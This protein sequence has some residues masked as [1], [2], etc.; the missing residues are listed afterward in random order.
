MNE[1]CLV[2]WTSIAISPRGDIA[3]CCK[4]V[5][6]N[7]YNITKD[8]IK[9]YSDSKYLNDIKNKMLASEWPAGCI[10]CKTEEDNN[11]KSKRQLDYE[12]WNTEWN[13]YTSDKGYIVASIA[14]GNTCNLKC[15]T[16]SSESSS[17]WRKEYLDLYGVDMAPIETIST[18][19]DEIY[20]AMPNVI[21]FDIP[22]GE[23]LL[24]EVQKQKALLSRYIKSGQS[25]N[26]TLHYTTNA[27]LFPNNEWWDIWSHFK[28]VD[29]QLSI[30]GIGTRYEYIRFPAKNELIEEH[31]M[32]YNESINKYPNLKLSVS[33][34]I[35]A[36]N[37]YYLSDFFDWCEFYNLPRPWCGVVSNPNH[38][39]PTV[40]PKP[41]KEKIVEHLNQSRHEDVRTWAS[42]LMKN[43]DSEHYP[44]FLSMKD[45]HDTYRNL[46]FA[47]TFSEVQELINGF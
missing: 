11:I 27:Q 21:H 41:I 32:M 18:E 30:D 6:K 39:R 44:M 9:E 43:N 40:Y 37:I 19:A 16:C 1:L 15:I 14:F 47:D 20:N 4:F 7:E 46:N 29:M 26:I 42:Y 12:R 31:V 24:S 2:P 5:N 38:M 28:E 22:G 35:S 34:T 3:P 23:P 8:T 13:E 33:H 36:Y 17:R 10:R 45:A 25:K